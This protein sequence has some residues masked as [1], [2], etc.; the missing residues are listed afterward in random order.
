MLLTNTEF[1]TYEGEVW[2]RDAKGDTKRLAETDYVFVQ[3]MCEMIETFYPK[4]Y[5]ALCEQY[6]GSALNRSF[7]RFRMVCRFV[8]CNFAALDSVPDIDCRLHCNFEYVA[9]PLRGECK[10]DRVICRPEFNHRL[11]PAETQVMKLIYEGVSEEEA[12]DRLCLSP[13]TVHSHIRNAYT[14]LGLHTRTE[15][16]RYAAQNN[17]FGN[18]QV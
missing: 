1:F 10:Y 8:K 13:H 14:R 2:I 5:A 4:A 17:I 15:F 7:F 3:E 11:S 18:E 16:A 6:K 9:C 12:A